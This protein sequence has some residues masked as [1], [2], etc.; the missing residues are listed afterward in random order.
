MNATHQRDRG[1]V[2][3][4]VSFLQ[5][6]VHFGTDERIRAAGDRTEAELELYGY[7]EYAKLERLYGDAMEF[8]LQQAGKMVDA[9]D[10][11]QPGLKA[12]LRSHG[13]GDNAFVVSFLIQQGERF[14]ARKGR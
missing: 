7:A 13:I 12:L 3:F 6:S 1:S 9:L 10:A 4:D 8:K 5:Q 14:H 2:L 11:K